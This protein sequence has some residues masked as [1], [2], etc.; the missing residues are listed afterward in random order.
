G[1]PEAGPVRADPV[2][3]PAAVAGA[4]RTGPAG[5]DAVAL[6]ASARPAA[7]QETSCRGD[8]RRP[9]GVAGP[10]ARAVSPINPAGR[11]LNRPTP[12]ECLS[13]EGA[14][15]NSQGRQPLENGPPK[16]RPSIARGVSPWKT[17]P[18]RGVRQ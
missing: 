10:P 12:T 14:S 11:P 4:H 5:N 18:R 17:Q 13:P 8:R 9:G 3:R 6:L 2:P 16:G 7:I 15:V 1:R